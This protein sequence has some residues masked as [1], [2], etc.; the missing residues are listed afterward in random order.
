MGDP[1]LK[2]L[3]RQLRD[4]ISAAIEFGW[5]ECEAKRGIY[6]VAITEAQDLTERIWRE[7]EFREGERLIRAA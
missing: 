3:V 5:S 1:E 7:L 4:E 6:V 2:E